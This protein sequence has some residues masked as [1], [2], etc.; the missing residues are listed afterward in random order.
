LNQF[1]KFFGAIPRSTRG[2]KRA[3]ALV[4]EALNSGDTVALFPEGHLS[5][6]G[7]IGQF[8]KGFELAT[9]GA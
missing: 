2:G 8:Q 4:T 7:H 6:N 3:L 1:F 5:R 9:A